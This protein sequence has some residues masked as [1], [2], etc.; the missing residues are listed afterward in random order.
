MIRRTRIDF[1]IRTDDTVSREELADSLALALGCSFA[2]GRFRKMP[3]LVAES[4]GV[5]I[6]LTPWS[7]IG[8]KKIFRLYGDVLEPGFVAETETETV[9]IERTDI[10][11]YMV[12]LLNIR[13]P[14]R[15]YVP[16][17]ADLD[18]ENEH[19]RAVDRAMG[20]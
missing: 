15:W 18:A 12:D 4:L 9:E 6:S 1:S 16:T 8:G 11:A 20:D 17:L 10:S 3:A 14:C 5:S 13:T 19:A 2:K 7:G